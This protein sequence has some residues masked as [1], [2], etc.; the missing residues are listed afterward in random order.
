VN[1]S[2]K[3]VAQ[4]RRSRSLNPRPL[5]RKSDGATPT[6][7]PP[8]HPVTIHHAVVLALVS[9]YNDPRNTDLLELSD[10]HGVHSL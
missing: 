10:Q 4:Q 7:K 1:N 5:D 2:P 3:V 6:A 8:R 9:L